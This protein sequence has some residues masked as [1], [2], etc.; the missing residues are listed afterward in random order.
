MNK[1]I[2]FYKKDQDYAYHF[3]EKD[4]DSITIQKLMLLTAAVMNTFVEYSLILR[5]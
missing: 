3:I 4:D 1:V 2:D 5:L